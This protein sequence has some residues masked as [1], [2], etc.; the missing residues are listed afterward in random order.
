VS[1]RYNNTELYAERIFPVL[2]VPKRTGVYFVYDKENLRAPV[3]TLRASQS[4]AERTSWNMTKSTY[5][6]LL[7][8][9]IEVGLDD[10]D[11]DQ[12]QEPLNLRIDAANL[13]TEKIMIEKEIALASYLDTTGNFASTNRV[14]LSGT[15]QWSD[16][17]NSSPFTDVQTG[18]SA[19][20]SVASPP[21]NTIGLNQQVWDKLKNHPDLLE[22]V[23][24]TQLGQ[25]TEGLLSTLF[26]VSQCFIM[27][28]VKNTAVDNQTDS[29]SFIWPKDFWLFYITQQP[30]LRQVSLGYTLTQEGKRYIDNWYEQGIK[31]EL[32][33]FTD[34]YQQ[35]V[36]ANVAMYLIKNAVA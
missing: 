8:H 32:V 26:E 7:E 16:Y 11:L 5:G 3:T 29:I 14:T 27:R 23:K 22:R 1:L 33:R 17:Q 6:P 18:R 31:T 4:R 13:V 35:Y 28:S 9:S 20:I 36:V 12:E 21:P 25:L 34:Y 24:Y 30:G 10:D 15:S 2:T 19:M